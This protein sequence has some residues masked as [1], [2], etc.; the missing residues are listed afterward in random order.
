MSSNAPVA[1]QHLSE[2]ELEGLLKGHR[3]LRIARTG[4]AAARAEGVAGEA[5]AARSE[6]D[7]GAPTPPSRLHR[8]STI[9]REDPPVHPLTGAGR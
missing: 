1:G 7:A 2:D 4:A 3:A 8:A 9:K 5:R 6:A